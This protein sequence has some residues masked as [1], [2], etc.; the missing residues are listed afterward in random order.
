MAKTIANPSETRGPGR[1]REFDLT[2]ALDGA[3][4]TFSEHGYHRLTAAM[5][6]AEGS[7]NLRRRPKKFGRWVHPHPARF[8]S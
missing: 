4:C 1:P 5:G 8:G 3:I 2:T 7:T 6:I